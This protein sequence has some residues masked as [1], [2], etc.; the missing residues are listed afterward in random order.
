M[1]I[2]LIKL[3]SLTTSVLTMLAR[4][5]GALG[6]SLSQYGRKDSTNDSKEPS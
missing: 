6:E 4:V 1:R 2:P 3:L 5:T